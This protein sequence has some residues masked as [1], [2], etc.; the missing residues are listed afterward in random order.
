MVKEWAC[1]IDVSFTQF[2]V[3]AETKEEFVEQIKELFMEEYNL[4]LKDHEIKNI[5]EIQEVKD[6]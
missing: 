1:E 4:E 6:D 5:Q 3:E 2:G